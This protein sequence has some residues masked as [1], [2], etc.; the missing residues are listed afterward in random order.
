M[1]SL[2]IGDNLE[3]NPKLLTARWFKHTQ[4]FNESLSFLIPVKIGFPCGYSHE[5]AL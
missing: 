4:L 1:S 5:N 2:F 3:I